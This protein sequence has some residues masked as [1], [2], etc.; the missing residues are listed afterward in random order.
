MK[1]YLTAQTNHSYGNT[2]VKRIRCMIICQSESKLVK[3]LV[4]IFEY[5]GP[6]QLKL[7]K[8]KLENEFQTK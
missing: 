2:S 4:N 6:D 5:M 3:K 8:N 1:L 7:N